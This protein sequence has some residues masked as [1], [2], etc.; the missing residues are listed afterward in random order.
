MS[1]ARCPECGGQV[2]VLERLL[3]GWARVRCLDDGIRMAK[4][5]A[6]LTPVTGP[7]PLRD[8]GQARTGDPET[9][10]LAAA[11][12]DPAGLQL[13]LMRALAAAGEGNRDELAARAGITQ[14]QAWRRL[15][16]LHDAGLIQPTGLTR[17]G[18]SGRQQTVYRMTQAG[19]RWLGQEATA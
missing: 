3:G 16:E 10:H 14:A 11:S 1:G 18:V 12:V 4:T 2:A 7:S 6:P 8:E 19:V 17:P 15:S 9:S 5:D 13:A